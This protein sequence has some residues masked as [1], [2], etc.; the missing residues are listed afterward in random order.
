M[1]YIPLKIDNNY[2]HIDMFKS[3]SLQI[4]DFF[5]IEILSTHNS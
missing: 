1:F 4:P 5:L 2:I 3:A